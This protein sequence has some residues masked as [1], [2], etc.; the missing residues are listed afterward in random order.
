MV[1]RRQGA[2]LSSWNAAITVLV[3][4]LHT[5]LPDCHAAPANPPPSATKTLPKW[6]NWHQF[7]DYTK[8]AVQDY[9]P[10]L[11][12]WGNITEFNLFSGYVACTKP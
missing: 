2:G 3:W 12:G 1:W 4:S 7:F 9:V 6:S 11:P 8:E 10:E 5:L